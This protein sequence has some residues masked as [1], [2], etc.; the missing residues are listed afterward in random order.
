[1]KAI[2]IGATGATGK[3]L[4]PLLATSSEIESIDCFGRRHPDFTHQKLNS[5]Q[6]DFS[7]TDDWRDEVQ[8]DVLFACLGTTLKAAGSK[9]AQWAIDYEANLEFAK[10]ARQN[11]VNA[12]VLLSASGA[13]SAS[14]LFYQRMKG[15]LEQAIIASNFPHLIIFRP[16]LLIR[17]NSDRL[18]E[19]IAEQILHGF[20]RIGLM[21]S[22]RPLAVEKLAQV[23]LKAA[24][25]QYRGQA[26]GSESHIQVYAPQDIFR[27][28]DQ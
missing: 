6:I 14:R 20:N 17:P 19:K 13:N 2:V 25:L 22:Q 11:G 23:M 12:L 16:S 9:E 10:V 18:G 5:H 24:L 7:Q 27:L 1:M 28:L 21:N 26:F 8:G 15:E 3:S 4:L